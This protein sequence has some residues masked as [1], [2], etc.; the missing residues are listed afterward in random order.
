[1]PW[2]QGVGSSNLPAPTN[3][4]NRLEDGHSNPQT[5]VHIEVP[6]NDP[7]TYVHMLHGA[8]ALVSR[9]DSC[10]VLMSFFS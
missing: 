1:M 8:A 10:L 4:S 5:S 6:G 9:E 7:P 3:D 2:A